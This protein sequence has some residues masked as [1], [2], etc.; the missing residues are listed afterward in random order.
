MVD[1]RQPKRRKTL[2]ACE[3]CRNKKTKCDG[4]RPVCGPCTRKGWGSDQCSWKYVD[5]TDDTIPNSLVRDLERRIHELERAHSS[6]PSAARPWDGSFSSSAPAHR[7][8]LPA[9]SPTQTGPGPNN[10][11]AIEGAVT[12]EPQNEG[13][14][15]P[16]AAAALMDTVRRAVAP[17][18]VAGSP[19]SQR[20]DALPMMQLTSPPSLSHL[21][22][23]RQEAHALLLSYWKYVHPIYPFLYRP[24]LESMFS[25]LW[26]GTTMPS[27]TSP[28]MQT[29]YQDSVCLI[30]L[31]LSLGCQYTVESDRDH[32]FRHGSA[33]ARIYFDRARAAYRYD[34]LGDVSPSLQQLQILLLMAQYLKSVGST[35]KA[36]DIMGLAIRTC[37]SLGLHLPTSSSTDA[38]PGFVDREMVKRVWHGCLMMERATT[39]TMFRM[40]SATL[41]RPAMVPAAAGTTTVPIP[42]EVDEENFQSGSMESDTNVHFPTL[43]SSG[44]VISFFVLSIELFEFV[45][46]ILLSFYSERSSDTTDSYSSYFVGKDSVL[47]LDNEMG[48]WCK[49]VPSYLQL[50]FPEASSPNHN[51]PARTFHRQAAVLRI[52][53]LQARIYLFRPVLSRICTT[54]HATNSKVLSERQEPTTS[55]EHRV[56]VQCSMLCVEEAI[57]LI[58]TMSTNITT[59]EVWGQ[60]PAWLYGV[61]HIYLAATVLLAARLAPAAL[62]TE[63]SEEKVQMAWRHALDILSGFQADSVS[64]QRCVAALEVLHRKLPN[65]VH[66][67]DYGHQSLNNGADDHHANDHGP[68][69]PDAFE[70]APP[71]HFGAN[72]SWTFDVQ[73]TSFD[74]AP[75]FDLSDPFDMSWFLASESF[76]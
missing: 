46:R 22:P 16:A 34:P 9:N 44:S 4:Q 19:V 74:W 55:L 53:Y 18:H 25:S 56:A 63:V 47:A 39:L 65:N 54:H 72:E 3:I 30:N 11:S 59:A 13:Y 36:W 2:L 69:N 17:L 33:Q 35:H 45:Q 10:I 32:E 43:L 21:L 51:S 31:V 29:S 40:L 70:L 42:L 38:I 75:D 60:K 37:Y 66:H 12:G 5:G 67:E 58:E 68:E 52:R 57:D 41:G 20:P 61:L 48:K 28:I 76:A 8:S 24:T 26:S 62:L 27:A 64:A 71:L 49:G 6:A 15:G 50:H 73:G 14:V 7:T 1:P 23:L